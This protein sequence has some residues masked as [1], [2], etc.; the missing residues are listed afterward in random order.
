MSRTTFSFAAV[1]F[2]GFSSLLGFTA[3]RTAIALASGEVSV[4][5]SSVKHSTAVFEGDRLRTGSNAGVLLHLRGATVQLAENSDVRYQGKRLS[6]LAG[7][8]L[9]RGA[10]A[11]A[12]GPFLIAALEDGQFQIQRIGIMTKLSLLSGKVRVSKGKNSLIIAGSGERH[13]SDSDEIRAAAKISPAKE[14]GAGAAGGATG[15]AASRWMIRSSKSEDLS[16][17]SPSN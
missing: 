12:S 4:N 1:F 9:I 7:S 14:I 5:G 15:A 10:E 11:V 3:E 6:L 17:K 16:H 8:A 13:F 2:F